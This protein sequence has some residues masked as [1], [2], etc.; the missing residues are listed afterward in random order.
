VRH[1]AHAEFTSAFHLP[2][3]MRAIQHHEIRVSSFAAKV[4]GTRRCPEFDQLCAFTMKCGNAFEESI[5]HCMQ[6]IACA[7]VW[8]GNEPHSR[9]KDM[10]YF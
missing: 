2:L 7:K 10:P 5:A 3:P 8:L 9:T 6:Q 1:D 4:S